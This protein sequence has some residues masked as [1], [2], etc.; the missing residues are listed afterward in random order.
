VTDHAMP[1][2]KSDDATRCIN[3]G[4]TPLKVKKRRLCDPC[5]CRW[6]KYGDPNGG[7]PRL[8]MSPLERF[9][10]Y[11]PDQA[12]P[13]SCWI[14][15]GPT[16]GREVCD[17]GRIYMG[18]DADQR[19]ALAHRWSY[20]HFIGPIPED[21][22]IDHVKDRGC[23]STLCVNPA[24]LEPVPHKINVL[25]GDAPSAKHARKECCPKCGGPYTEYDGRR[26][27]RPCANATMRRW[28][29]ETGRTAKPRTGSA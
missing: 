13:S 6:Q 15:T 3:C 16:L 2:A 26:G 17:Y 10:Y 4:G 29:L 21:K 7:G 8:G 20:E 11:V 19:L 27:C 24:H 12:D 9:N 22:E 28:K 18:D 5:Y 25:R 14:W 23:T 1:D